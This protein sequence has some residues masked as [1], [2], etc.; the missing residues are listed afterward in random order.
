MTE[1]FVVMSMSRYGEGITK[2]FRSLLETAQLLGRN[3]RAIDISGNGGI[4]QLRTE[5]FK[6]ARREL[7]VNTVR[8]LMFDSD[9]YFNQPDVLA[10]YIMAADASGFDL[11][12]DYPH[13]REQVTS[14]MELEHTTY[15]REKKPGLAGTLVPYSD[16]EYDALPDLAE[17]SDAGLGFFYGTLPLDYRF[18][19]AANGEDINFFLDNEIHPHLMKKL[20]LGHLKPVLVRYPERV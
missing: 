12:A 9:I 1:D 2:T 20:R 7:G 19:A 13:L 4:P 18:H 6:T 14:C 10:D 3:Y 8:G 16:E 5:L 17:V 15:Y 11:A